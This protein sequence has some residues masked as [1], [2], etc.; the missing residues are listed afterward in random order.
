MEADDGI[1]A[2]SIFSKGIGYTYDDFIILPGY[3]DFSTDDIQL[4]TRITKNI[5]LHIPLVSSPMDTVTES[6]M[7]IAMA[8]QGGIGIVHCNNTIE[9]QVNEILKVKRFNNG[10]IHDP[11]LFKPTDTVY[12]IVTLKKKHNLSFSSFPITI[13]GLIGSKLVGI[14]YRNDIDFIEDVNIKIQDVM[15]TEYIYAFDGC[16]LKDAN[17]ILKK[18]KVNVLPILNISGEL[19][20]LICRKDLRN[21]TEYPLASK[22]KETKQLLVGAAI[23][24][25]NYKNRVKALV[26]AGVDVVVIDSAQGNSIYQIETL[27]WIKQTYPLLDVICGNVVTCSQAHHL[28]ENGADAL[29]VGMGVGSICTT[30]NVCGVGRAQA[31]AVYNV[32]RLAHSYG[33]PIIADGGISN[34]SHIIKALALGADTVMMGSLLAGTDESPSQYFYKDG[35]RVKK[36]RGMGSLGA[37]KK[38]VHCLTRYLDTK[39]TI[40]V[41]QG[42]S[43]LVTCK[44]SISKYIPYLIKG[45][46]L[47]LQDIGCPSLEKL[48]DDNGK[49]ITKYEIRTLS[50][51]KES[52]VHG[53]V[54]ID[55]Y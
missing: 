39:E 49:G 13:D 1:S 52:Q 35:I 23:T 30:Q 38:S 15:T 34:T 4:R 29:R 3:I 44:G 25:R 51:Y 50:S 21:I 36:Y 18:N 22:N 28:I 48:H 11:V 16:S 24:T 26:Q 45:I 17:S 54:S 33:I 32:A 55:E 12:D 31:T 47:G 10:F 7:A 5:S 6:S 43:G 14:L 42:V 19:V 2:Q 46:L 9:E 8:L 40:K 53:L 41:A 27:R 37:M 20:S